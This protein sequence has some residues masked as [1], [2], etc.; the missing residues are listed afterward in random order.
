MR[1]ARFDVPPR[2]EAVAKGQPATL[3]AFN[4]GF[5]QAFA[6]H[7]RALAVGGHTAETRSNTHQIWVVRF[8]KTGIDPSVK[9][10]GRSDCFAPRPLSN[11][12][13]SKNVPAKVIDDTGVLSAD[14]DQTL[15]VHDID[16]DSEMRKL[17]AAI[18]AVFSPRMAI[19]AA[20]VAPEALNDLSS[21]KQALVEK[22]VTY[23]TP[24]GDAEDTETPEN[25]DAAVDRYRQE[26]LI[27][28]SNFY[29]MVS[30]AVVRLTTTLG[31]Q[32]PKSALKFFGQPAFDQPDDSGT[33][34]PA[35][36]ITSGKAVMD[37][38]GHP[39]AVGLF[40]KNKMRQRSFAADISLHLSAIEFDTETVMV[41]ETEFAVGSWLKLIDPAPALSI[42]AVDIPIPLRAF[43][44]PPELRTLTATPLMVDAPLGDASE[45]IAQAKSWSLDGAYQHEFAAQDRVDAIVSVNTGSS[46]PKLAAAPGRELIDELVSFNA[47]YPKIEAIF[48]AFDLA[49]VRTPDAAESAPELAA[50]LR[51]LAALVKAVVTSNWAHDTNPHFMGHPMQTDLATRSCRYA[52]RDGV[53]SNPD[54]RWRS[55]VSIAEQGTESLE[56]LPMLQIPGCTTELVSQTANA[57]VYQFAHI[58]NGQPFSGQDGWTERRRILAMRPIASGALF[59]A[60]LNVIDRQNG[61]IAMKITR[62]ADLPPAFR[63]STDW[64]KYPTLAAPILDIDAAID[65]SDLAG[66]TPARIADHVHALLS[67]IATGSGTG[68]RSIGYLQILAGFEYPITT[69][70]SDDVSLPP[71]ELPI[72]LQVPKEVTLGSSDEIQ[73]E[74]ATSIAEFIESWFADNSLAPQTRP[75]Q[76]A[77]SKLVFD[78]SVFSTGARIGPPILRFKRLE[79]P[80]TAI[81]I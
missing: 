11:H 15:T 69:A 35:F 63:Y 49:S 70:G 22:F 48:D 47:L 16:L 77:A 6:G 57:A 46:T 56:M 72:L 65:I 54:E 60:P 3:K 31:G 10:P 9:G 43:P 33:G 66:A 1:E 78:I 55:E 52:I 25:L 76:W 13:I 42:G 8:G 4:D 20:L 12:L 41:G 2:H 14:Y 58:Q 19:P 37:P 40:A 28:L 44:T 73:T 7:D 74:F 68:D 80:A 81:L 30:V 50:A 61:S 29:D 45:A 51:S 79:L 34:E 38:S 64:V 71:I 32:T 21:S 23:V 39:M 26:C 59:G 17:I 36:S 18:D 75:G 62:N 27:S 53:Q 67:A 24:L 5:R